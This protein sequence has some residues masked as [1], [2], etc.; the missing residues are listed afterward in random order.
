MLLCWYMARTNRSIYQ[1][2]EYE[3]RI[4]RIQRSLRRS[5]A[6]TSVATLTSAGA[7]VD[8]FTEASISRFYNSTVLQNLPWENLRVPT[9]NVTPSRLAI[10]GL[11]AAVGIINV[12]NANRA[13]AQISTLETQATQEVQMDRLTTATQ[14]AAGQRDPSTVMVEPGDII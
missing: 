10:A 6:A 8:A 12:V 14:L 5:R 9:D 13:Q 7:V 2:A 1:E 3:S 11:Y 4:P